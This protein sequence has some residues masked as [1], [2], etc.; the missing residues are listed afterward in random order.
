MKSFKLFAAVLFVLSTFCAGFVSAQ[1]DRGTIRGTVLDPSGSV[2][3]GAR[4]VA[5]SVERGD[6]RETTTGDTGI[7]V[8]PE[9]K[10]G[11]YQVSVEV[12]GFKRTSIDNVKVDVQGTQSL[13]I[14]LEIGEVTGNV[15]TVNAEAVTLNTDTPVRQSN[16]TE[17]QVRELPLL[18]GGETE[19][20][21]PLSFIFLDSNVTS[22]Q[23]DGSNNT[24]KFKVSGGQASGTEIL[25]DG[26]A[27]RR[28]QNGT[29]FSEVAPSPNAFQELTISTSSYSAEF[30][31][32]SGGVVN[33]TIKSGGNDFHGEAYDY[34]RNEKFDA[35]DIFNN[36]NGLPRNRDNRNNYGFNVGGP[37]YVPNFG[38]GTPGGM[39]RKLKDR[40]FFFFHYEGYRL[41]LG[42]N[43]LV[44][45]PTLKMRSGDFSELLNTA[46]PN[47]QRINGG[48][49]VLIYDPRQPSATRTPFA[50]NIIPQSAIDPAGLAILQRFPVPTR[51]GIFQNYDAQG[52]QPVD[53]NQYT[54]KTDFVL[55]TKQR[56][57]FSFSRRKTDRVV[58]IPI[59][60]LPFTNQDIFQQ[61]FKSN[62]GRIQYDY[63]ITPTLL[64]HFNLGYTFFDVANRNTTDPFDTSSL[65]IPAS[66][67]QNAAFP[68][69]GFPGYGSNDPRNV[70]NIGSSFFTDRIK[71]ATLEFSDFVTYIRGRNAFKLGAD[72][73]SSQFNVRQ[74]IDPGGSFNFRNDQTASDACGDCGYPIASLITGATEFAFN[75]N[76]SIDPAFRQLTQG[77]F[78]QDDIK[79]SQKLTVNVGLRY[80]LPGL[81]TEAHDRFR[82][83][84][85][86]APNPQAGGRLGALVGAGGQSGLTAAQR[87]LAKNDKSNIGP[88][89][90]AAYAL[91]SKTVIRGGI[92]LYYAPVLY[93]TN[94]GGDINT[95]TIGYNTTGQ[96][97]TPAGRNA[98]FFLSS[99]PAIPA[100]DPNSQFVGNLGVP[101]LAFGQFEHGF[102]TGR[103][104]QYTIDLQRELPYRLVASI[105]YIG[106]RADRL[107]SNFGRPNALSLNQLKLGNEILRTDINAVTAAQRAYA[108][109]IGVT[110]PANGNAV[111]PG[112]GGNV[113]QAIRPF[114]QYGRITDILESEGE[115]TYNAMQIKVDRRFAQGFQ[116]GASYTLSRL[117][118]N[119]SEDI[120]GGSPLDG[121]LQNP[122]DRKALK[123]ISPTNS[124]NIFVT[125]FLAELPFGKGKK[126]LNNGG[127][128]DKI[129]GGFQ[130][131]GIFRIQQ[132]TPLVFSLDPDPNSNSSA[133]PGGGFLELA[134]IFGRLR[135]NLTG[136]PIGASQRVAVPGVPGRFLI[137]NPAAFSAPPDYNAAPAFLVNG[138]INPAYTAYYADPT[139]FFGTAPLVNT[140][141]RSDRYF[142]AD[143]NILKKTR[144]TETVALE[145][146]AEFFNVF[147][148]VLYLPPDTF[149]GQQ[150]AGSSNGINRNNSN[151]GAEGFIGR[152]SP[153]TNR[154]I[155]FRARLIF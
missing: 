25:V 76:N 123:T 127:F 42:Q 106:H 35:N 102:R 38:E 114:P 59:L 115:A 45:V 137:L 116:F 8:L 97:F 87:T 29:F 54:I 73:R 60:P 3:S 82:G 74:K 142:T 32:S 153:G 21:S 48:R 13:E 40:A 98:R 151:F 108:T 134:G 154:A 28:Q 49:P 57:S 94:G 70:I 83:F 27:A 11:L 65:G 91:N 1:S 138:A 14:K 63:N 22:A 99:F 148:Q 52:L 130:I 68:R 144:I 36:A 152:I 81:R 9:L 33:F 51:P 55:T 92:G 145:L 126:F 23:S 75:S 129:F 12:A 149:L 44:T 80:D 31:N 89:L 136:Q 96:L 109:S 62:I 50:G 119:A 39:F 117:I 53:T 133:I 30:G 5:T 143:M 16:V 20:R 118:T 72:V 67:T 19:G 103:T 111:Y 37:I 66:A 4:V 17:K 110:I 86:T 95:G 100:T 79:V 141:F 71:D 46:D 85:P 64:N 125:N 84:V 6:T 43:T 56:L 101:I 146:G 2:V 69:I 41:R 90:G 93:G 107:R 10:A 113:A 18:V 34:V 139:R 135:P 140:D 132:G 61:N 26:A 155:Q 7:F 122:Y 78:I 77:Y 15:V 128:V 24:S 104:L 150:A 120:L 121:V 131:S 147:N 105:G 112:F 124:P 58:G 88:R 47:V